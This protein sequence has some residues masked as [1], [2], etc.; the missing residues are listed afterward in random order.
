MTKHYP[1][2]KQQNQEQQEQ[3]TKEKGWYCLAH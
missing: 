1:R 3:P 2:S